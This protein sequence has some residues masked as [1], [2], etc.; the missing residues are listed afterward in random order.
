MI[1]QISDAKRRPRIDFKLVVGIL[2]GLIFFFGLSML[3]PYLVALGYG[4]ASASAF[5]LSALG[6]MAAGGALFLLMKPREELRMR[7]AFMIVSFTWL[8]GSL[9]GALPFTLSGTLASYTDAVFEAMSGLSTTGATI[10][11]GETAAGIQNPTIEALDKSLLFWRSLMHWLGGMG[12]I[13][14]TLALLPLL[15]IGGMQLFKAEY[16]GSTSDKLTPRIRETAMLL[17]SVYIGMTAVQYLLLWAH[18]SMDWFEAINHAMSTLAT[19]GYSTKDASVAAFDSVYID[20]VIILFMY[21]AGINFA[22][23]FRLFTG[24]AADVFKNREV[25]FYTALVAVFILLISLVLWQVDGYGIGE[26]V[27]YGSFQV[28]AIVTTTGFG[29]DDYTLWMPLGG[30]LLFLLFFTGGCAGSTGG[31]MKM[32]RLLIIIKNIKREIKKIMHPQA[33]LPVHVGPRIID[34]PILK[35]ILGFFVMYFIIFAAGALVMSA[36]GYDLE[37]AIGASIAS[38]GNIGP[39][40]GEFGPA[41]NYA[42]IPI[43]GKWVLLLL[44]MVGR[45]ELFT[46][47]VLFTPWFWKN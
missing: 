34:A 25:R 10:L 22:L 20:V 44:M 28:L 1:E 18:P 24:N 14:L 31:G 9:V 30:F 46:V 5:L 3:L 11:G 26:A 12:I 32:I 7:E 27:R 17:W 35:N 29:T 36:L 33:V 15:G 13:V 4:E 40:W 45:L 47:L 43:I 37:S 38:L 6:A 39:A 23:H 2:G 21:L 8:V 42:G 19:G 16:S 41:D